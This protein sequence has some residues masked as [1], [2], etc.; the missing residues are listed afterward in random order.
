MKRKRA[1]REVL[2]ENKT[3]LNFLPISKGGGLQNSLSFIDVLSEDRD[4]K[5]Q[6]LA[7]VRHGS[8]LQSACETGGVDFIP[9]A[10]GALNRLRFELRCRELF[11]E[12][13]VCFT[14]FGPPM[15]GSSR[16]CLNVVGCAY[17]NLF[18]PDIPFWSYLSR[19]QRFVKELVDDLRRRMISAADYWIFETDILRRRALDLCGFPE[20][21]V[22]VVRMAP[23]ELVSP[24]RVKPLLRQ[25]FQR[26]LPEGFRFLFLSGPH[27]NKRIHLLADI[28]QN[29]Q[30]HGYTNFFFVTTMDETHAYTVHVKSE[31][32]RR[33]VQGRLVNIGPIPAEDVATLIDVADA[34]CNFSI[35][36]S[37]SNNFVEAWRMRRPLI[38]TDAEWAIG[39]CGDAAFY[40]NLENL[41]ETVEALGHIMTD[42]A[43][44]SKIV[45]NGDR[46]LTAYPTA[47][48]KY[49]LYVEEIEKATILGLCSAKERASIHWP[50]RQRL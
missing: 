35:L 22:G 33:H 16:Y 40:I 8:P 39:S 26:S 27:S 24:Q 12:G 19:K 31:F 9:V 50:G 18:Y 3:V 44:R 25:H 14:Y 5:H 38:V 28:A 32:A 1:L 34:L 2:M 42:S 49:E 21:R 48:R 23:S 45:A 43:L 41:E 13:Q 6:Y 20:N 46:Q 47:Q 11:S 30:Y 7:I 4:K 17:S 15:V 29:M 36:E 37:F 10:A